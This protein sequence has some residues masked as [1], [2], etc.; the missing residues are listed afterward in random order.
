MTTT[1]WI[2]G[3]PSPLPGY[4]LITR[5]EIRARAESGR[6]IFLDM[7]SHRLTQ[8]VPAYLAVPAR[9]FP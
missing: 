2:A 9:R 5:P 7:F 1:L 4:Y 6:A 3:Q 8:F